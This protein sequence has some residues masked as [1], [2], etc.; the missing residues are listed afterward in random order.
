MSL[1]VSHVLTAWQKEALLI[2]QNEQNRCP[3]TPLFK[4]CN[5][6]GIDLY[7]KDETL[8]PTGTHKHRLAR[9]L[10]SCALRRGKIN[11][12]TRLFEASSGSTARSEAYF[13]KKL[14]L[15]YTTVVNRETPKE[16]LDLINAEGGNIVLCDPGQD[17]QVARNLAEQTNGYFVDQFKF[18]AL[19]TNYLHDNIASELHQQLRT[20]GLGLPEFIVC[21][22]GTGGVSATLGRYFKHHQLKS[23]I[24]V[25][26]PDNSAFY[27]AYLC[28]DY[29][30]TTGKCSR[31]GGIGRPQVEESF[32]M[33]QIDG[34]IQVPDGAS[35]AAIHF[36]KKHFN[37]WMGGSTG[38]NLFGCFELIDKM[39]RENCKGSIVTFF[40]D[41][42]LLYQNT[43]YNHEWIEKEGLK[44]EME[45][46]LKLMQKRKG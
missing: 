9:S 41:S 28:K 11:E 25:V 29:S 33:D 36:L 4:L 2:L 15:E 39:H 43:Y 18:A 35:L 32:L 14:G 17:K 30:L 16:K 10:L 37:Y 40:F 34:M 19:S 27:P 8:Q 46:Y 3:N 26:D 44:D 5:I 13:A 20:L 22:S 42:G 7:V 38:T 21:G 23:K 24:I 45:R 31:I 1:I 12:N 6:S